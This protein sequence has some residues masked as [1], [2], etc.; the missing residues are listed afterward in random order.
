MRI[1]RNYILREFLSSFFLLIALFTFVLVTG[2]IIKLA[3]LIINKG[4]DP[5]SAAKLLIYLAPYLLTFSMPMAVLTATLLVFGR[6]SSDNEIMVMRT[7]GV[8]LGRIFAPVI[9]VGFIISLLGIPLNDRVLPESHF[10]ARKVLKDILIKRPTAYLESGAIIREFEDYIIMVHE[11]D[12]NV[13]KNIRIYQPQQGKPTRTIVASRGE[14]EPIEGTDAIRVKLE[15]G[16]SDEPNPTNP[17]NFYKLNFETYYMTLDLKD[18]KDTSKLG[19]KLKE[20]SISELQDEMVKLKAENI[21][22]NPVKAE[23]H[24]KLVLAFSNLAFILIAL[25]L[26]ITVR[27]GEKTI[28]F[29]ISLAL[30]VCYWLLLAG[31]E[32][33]ASRGLVEPWIGM[34]TPD[35]ILAAIGIILIAYKTHKT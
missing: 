20:M 2:N 27:R 30:I 4:V 10:A 3:D 8:S 32:A 15:N 12:K 24:K 14:F 1:I 25:P 26:A 7:S 35:I 16:T 23:I 13:M 33:V 17:R 22:I 9:T 21:D 34:W 18:F 6:L 19:K 31:A 11:V 28:G 5:L 29:G